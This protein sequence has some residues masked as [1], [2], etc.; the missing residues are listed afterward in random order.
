[1][2]YTC[3][4]CKYLCNVCLYDKINLIYINLADLVTDKWSKKTKFNL[5]IHS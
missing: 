4:K 1:M 5:F 3:L 2:F